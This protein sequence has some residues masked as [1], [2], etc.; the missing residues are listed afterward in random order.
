MEFNVAA[1]MSKTEKQPIKMNDG[2]D[3]DDDDEEVEDHS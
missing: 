2:V 1:G 3:N